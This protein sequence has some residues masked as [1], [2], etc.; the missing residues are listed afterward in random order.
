MYRIRTCVWALL[1]A[2]FAL[3]NA[4]DSLTLKESITLVLQENTELLAADLAH[5][6]AEYSPAA[7]SAIPDPAFMIEGR[8]IPLDASR[9]GETREIM[10]MLE[11]MFPFPGTL[12]HQHQA[13]E[14]EAK[15]A[16]QMY[17]A[18]QNNL[19]AMTKTV[20]YEIAF[21]DAALSINL[22]HIQ[23][24][25]DFYDIAKAKYIVNQA[26]Q[27][28]L[29]RIT[30][31]RSRLQAKQLELEEQ[32]SNAQKQLNQLL[33][34]PLLSDVTV[35]PLPEETMT[36]SSI[37]VDSLLLKFHPALKSAEIRLA[38]R[39]TDIRIARDTNKPDFR[40][41]GGYMAMNDRDDALMGRLS[42]TLPFMP[43][44]NKDSHAQIQQAK[45]LKNKQ[46]MDWVTLRDRLLV[47]AQ[48][49]ST[50]LQSQ[51]ERLHVYETEILPTSR[52]AVD[53]ALA[54]YQTG[55]EDLLSLIEY[56]RELLNNE[57]EWLNLRKNIW[58]T[59]ADL[60]NAVGTTLEKR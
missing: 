9:F 16:E 55:R 57:L 31:E 24:M 3:A 41:M 33:R 50:T 14:W 23:L 11:Q 60:E 49:L 22:T 35:A 27:Q 21:Y 12:T 58:Q 8:G 42:M 44:S 43:W 36:M 46:E 10:F 25:H 52:Q 13:G 45:I 4:Q 29:F 48:S 15:I 38:A 17:R 54:D 6:A 53:L 5:Q 37:A 32:R 39:D 19:T 51:K 2:Y 59:F 7:R 26:R 30:I 20:Y 18:A 47:K 40:V 34:R 1:L 28:D 56:E